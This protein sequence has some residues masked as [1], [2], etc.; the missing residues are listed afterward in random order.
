[1]TRIELADHVESAFNLGSATRGDLV[2]A[3]T[4]SQARPEVVALLR[5]L[6]DGQFRSLRE[7]WRDLADVPVGG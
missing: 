2:A 7:L 3:A 1:V 5:G 6:P 4:A